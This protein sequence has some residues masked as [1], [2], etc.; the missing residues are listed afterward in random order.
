MMSD[1][2]V[3]PKWEFDCPQ[4][5]DFNQP[6][7]SDDNVDSFFDETSSKRAKSKDKGKL[8]N[9]ETPVKTCKTDSP[10]FQTPP[11]CIKPQLSSKKS[12]S[13]K[14]SAKKVC[15]DIKVPEN[16]TE[17]LSSN[18]ENEKKK[19]NSKQK[20]KSNNKKS[21]ISSRLQA[22][23]NKHLNRLYNLR[24]TPAKTPKEK[25]TPKSKKAKL[26]GKKDTPSLQLSK[27]LT[28]S[29]RSMKS[30]SLTSSLRRSARK[31]AKKIQYKS[32]SSE[33]LNDL[34]KVAKKLATPQCS[35]KTAAAK[36]SKN[37][38]SS[39]EL[40][41]EKIADLRQ[42][43][44]L[45]REMAKQSMKRAMMQP[46]NTSVGNSSSQAYHTVAKP[47]NF[48]TDQRIKGSGKKKCER[49]RD[50]ISTLRSNSSPVSQKYHDKELTVPIPFNL[51]ENR[52]RKLD[53]QENYQT[54]AEQIEAFQRGAFDKFG[55][56]AKNTEE[57]GNLLTIPK[58]P[59]LRAMSR[60]RPVNVLSQAE[61]EELLLQEMKS[62]KFKATAINPKILSCSQNI[63]RTTDE[64]GKP[65]SKERYFLR[66]R[67]RPGD[68]DIPFQFHANPVP[69][70]ILKG[71][72]GIKERTELPV[73][74]PKS[75][76]LHLKHRAE[77]WK[78]QK[79]EEKENSLI[80]TFKSRP[81][82]HVG[83]P[84]RP[85]LDTKRTVLEPFSFEDRDRERWQ[86]KAMKIKEEL[87]HQK[88]VEE[89]H[90]Q[91]MPNYSDNLPSVPKKPCT[92]A[93]PFNLLMEQRSKEKLEKWQ[94]EIEEEMNRENEARI[95]KAKP[96]NV[97]YK[98]PFVPEKST[99]PLSDL[100]SIYLNTERR[101]AERE[102]FEY[103]KNLRERE[104]EAEFEKLLQEREQEELEEIARYRAK[105]VH[106][107][108][109]VK[110]YVPLEIQPSSIKLTQPQS[111]HLATKL[112]S[113]RLASEV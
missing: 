36:S 73:T 7:H 81:L 26:A 13:A 4:F 77:M 32:A 95:F 113:K 103:L 63:S 90:A 38:K 83:V 91:P 99:K 106:R 71:V 42:Q 100:T 75:P 9:K 78:E 110:H 84:F 87:L 6:L 92:Q 112:R 107:A 76:N 69:E 22:I 79:V 58:T 33:N 105:I 109:P 10:E 2:E 80:H 39:E 23:G 48:A 28:G 37:I 74:K 54:L 18:D 31:S 15:L 1:M 12:K 40:E 8:K 41:M 89:F 86:L 102:K 70:K 50:F 66:K 111:P 14:K 61:R 59:K 3:D 96:S 34:R 67:S 85:K 97:L 108:R 24:R 57:K 35:K 55:G 68:D 62:Y 45:H 56:L 65:E 20:R 101:A 94:K 16:L 5:V 21:T 46:A 53:N 98:S 47:F 43:L 44:S 64:S 27:A 49:E 72:V 51:T 52:K 19:I 25:T 104:R 29:I 82:P 30:R 60:R 17:I 88:K 93:E 11:S